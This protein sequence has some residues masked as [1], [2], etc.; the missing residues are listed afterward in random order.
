MNLAQEVRRLAGELDLTFTEI[1][2]RIGQ[3]PANLSKK[4]TK[5]T[6]SFEDFAKILQAMG[7]TMECRFI[8]PDEKS[9]GAGAGDPRT[10]QQLQILEQQLAVERMKSQYFSD[11]R[12]DMRTAL[13]T[14]SGGLTLAERRLN[15]PEKARSCL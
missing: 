3:S 6:L 11:I 12:H 13:D 15:D 1:A 10:R 8:L 4:L 2:R 5:E 9:S 7:V 14:I